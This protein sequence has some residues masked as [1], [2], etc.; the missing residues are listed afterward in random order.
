MSRQNG[1]AP[2]LIIL[3][4]LAVIGIAGGAYYL[5]MSKSAISQDRLAEQNP[6][7]SNSAKLNPTNKPSPTTDPTDTS[8]TA[9]WRTY[10]SEKLENLSYE[11]FSIKYPSTW[12]IREGEAPDNST[13]FDTKEDFGSGPEP[14]RYLVVISYINTKGV[15]L[16]EYLKKENGITYP[17]EIESGKI[18]DYNIYK[19]TQL[20]SRASNLSY[21][22][23]QNDNEYVQ[24]MLTPYEKTSE[25]G[26]DKYNKIF[27]QMLLSFKFIN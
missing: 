21:F 25:L 23:Y 13:Y 19:T 6:N 12:S 22:L 2:I 9:N 26:Q 15:P 4:V 18:G 14:N 24:L 10:T 16:K 11:V 5:G 20:P 27:E 8:E 3:V 17:F 1:F 7:V